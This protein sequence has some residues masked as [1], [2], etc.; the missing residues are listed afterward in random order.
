MRGFLT[1]VLQ[2]AWRSRGPLACL[3]WPVSQLYSALIGSRAWLYR[4]GIFSAQP[5]GVP[6]I[7]VGN[8]VAGGGGK[9][10]L[11]MALVAHFSGQGIQVG[12]ISRG[13][14]RKR[15]DCQEVQFDTPIHE[16]GDEPAFIKRAQAAPVFVANDR[17]LA[18]KSLLAAYPQTRLLICDDGLQHLQLA[19]TV[20]I[21]VFDD[22]GLG[23]AWLLPAGPLRQH[24]PLTKQSVPNLVLHTGV[25]PAFAGFSSTRKLAEHAVAADGTHVSLA[26]LQ[27]SSAPDSDLI[28]LAGIAHP[29]AFFDMLRALGL[30]LSRTIAMADHAEFSPVDLTNLQQ[31][32]EGQLTVLCTEKDAVKLF[33]LPQIPG[34]RI[35]ATPLLFTPEAAFFS[36]LESALRAAT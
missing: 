31:P 33:A 8:V 34:V 7:V 25:K 13:Y 24:W 15:K 6:T 36:A 9:T 1:S 17:V 14:G 16:S 23:N 26:S 22:T 28:A 27:K 35:L 20:N 18:A 19:R 29:D 30:P 21:T 4:R 10:P 11:V 2:Q 32:G 3:L 5:V 12:V